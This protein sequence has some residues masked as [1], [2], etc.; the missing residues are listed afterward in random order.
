M[1]KIRRK[2]DENARKHW[3]NQQ[4]RP[5]SVVWL[6]CNEI[7]AYNQMERNPDS[8]ITRRYCV[9]IA[10]FLK[11]IN[12]TKPVNTRIFAS[13]A[14]FWM[15][16]LFARFYAKKHAEQSDKLELKKNGVTLA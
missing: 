14:L 1:R 2:K 13:N 15:R 5:S 6:G 16:Y 12:P 11:C 7:I 3:N 8:V 9:T 4:F 10:L